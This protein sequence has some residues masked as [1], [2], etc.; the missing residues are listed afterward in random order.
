MTSTHIINPSTPGRADTFVIPN[1]QFDFFHSGFIQATSAYVDFMSGVL[2]SFTQTS[3]EESKIETSESQDLTK[4]AVVLAQQ[5]SEQMKAY[6]AE[7]AS[8]NSGPTWL[9]Y[10]T[11]AVMFISCLLT[12]DWAMASMA[13]GDIIMTAT[14]TKQELEQK[15]EA[16]GCPELLADV[17]VAVG[18]AVLISLPRAGLDGFT[19]AGANAAE[20]LPT[21]MQKM[22]ASILKNLPTNT[23][24]TLSMGSFWQ[25]SAEKMTSSPEGQAA[26]SAI[27]SVAAIGLALKFGPEGNLNG[28]IK[29]KL[30][31]KFPEY[32]EKVYFASLMGLLLAQSGFRLAQNVNQ[33]KQGEAMEKAA[34]IIEKWGTF[35]Q[36]FTLTQGLVDMFQVATDTT[37]SMISSVNNNFVGVYQALPALAT[38]LKIPQ[39]V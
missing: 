13:L 24:I 29:N 39:A 20:T 11:D 9:N 19:E 33:I 2:S 38:M 8:Q 12:E 4:A 22:L 16:A 14:G 34:D 7:L 1:E 21:K 15:L 5:A 23:A 3:M 6:Q 37:Q 18:M 28:Y 31:A 35:Q 36:Q 32:G 10:I 25:D 26:I 30:I 17:T 27:F